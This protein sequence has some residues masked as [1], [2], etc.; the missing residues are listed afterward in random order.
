MAARMMKNRWLL[1][2]VTVLVVAWWGSCPG[3]GTAQTLDTARAALTEGRYQAAVSQLEELVQKEPTNLGTQYWLGRARLA[4]GDAAG[5]AEVFEKILEVKADSLESRLWLGR[6]LLAADKKTEARAAFEE[7]LARQADQREAKQALLEMERPLAAEAPADLL[8]A[9]ARELERGRLIFAGAGLGIPVGQSDITSANVYDYTFSYAPTDWI[10]RSGEWNATSRWT[11]SPQWSWYGGYSPQGLAAFWNKRQFMGDITVELHLAF[12]MRMGR[13]PVYMHPNDINITICG[14]GANLDSGYAFI[15]G[16]DDN[17]VTR[18]M[19]G[20]RVIAESRDPAALFP[21]YEN[22]QPATYEWHRKWWSLRARKSGTRLQL[23]LDEK[24]ILEGDDPH[25]LPGGRVALWVYKNDMITPRVKIYYEREKLP[26]DPMPDEQT[27]FLPVTSVTSPAVTVSSPSHPSFQADFETDLGSWT[28]REPDQGATLTIVPGGPDGQGHCL[29]LVNM[30][31][32]GHFGANVIPGQFDLAQLPRLRFDY[33]LDPEARVNFYFTCGDQRYELGFSGL[34]QCAPGYEM[35]GR[36]PGVRADGQWHQADYDLL[37]ALQAH[38]GLTKGTQC[39]GLWAGNL[40]NSTYLQA[41][42][43]GNR[44]GTQWEI[45]NFY[46]GHPRTGDV[47]VTVTPRPGVEI[48][49]LAVNLVPGTEGPLPEQAEIKDGKFAVRATGEGRHTVQ[50]RPLLK[51][52]QWGPV[53]RYALWVD[54]EAPQVVGSEPAAGGTL[55][56]GKIELQLADPGGSGV[57]L[58]ALKLNLAG[59]SLG[60]DSPAVAYDPGS[61]KVTLDLQQTDLVLPNNQQAVLEVAGLVDRAG[62]AVAESQPIGFVVDY[63]HDRTPPTVPQIHLGESY[64]LDNDFEHD[65]GEWTPYGGVS[66]AEL[67][68]DSTTASSGTYSLRLHNGATGRRFGAYITQRPFDAGKYRMVSF[69]YKCDDRLRADLAVY[70]NGAW[71]SIRFTD[72]DNHTNVIGQV[73]NVITDN[74][75]HTTSFNLYDMLRKADGAANFIVRQ[76]IISDWNWAGNRAGATYHIDDFQLIPVISGAAPVKA[77]WKSRDWSGIGGA[78]WVW[79]N[80]MGT[81]PAKKIMGEASETQLDLSE[82]QD[83][84]LHVRTQDRA[85]NWS[86]AGHRR[87]LVD[88]EAPAAQIYSPYPDARHAVS[89]VVVALSDKGISGVDPSTLKLKVGDSEYQVDGQGL[90]FEYSQGKLIWNCER[91]QPNPVVF[92]D[93]TEVDVA[94]LAGADYAGNKLPELPRWK[95]VMDYSLDQTPPQV[96]EIY[97]TTHPTLVTNTFEYGLGYWQNRGGD[98]GAKVELVTD[99]AADGKGCVQLTNQRKGGHM[100]AFVYREPYVVEKYPI[101]AFDYR[102]PAG[103]RLALQF[104]MDGRW[105]AVNLTDEAKDIIGQVPDII[106]DGKWRH[107]QFD[108]MPLLRRHKPQ[109]TLVVNQIFIGDRGTMNNEA[110][111]KAWFDNF[112]IG[113]VG[114]YAPVLRWRATDTTGISGYSQTLSRDSGAVPAAESEGTEVAKTF[115]NLEAGIWY[116][117]VRARDGAGNW[118]PPRTYAILHQNAD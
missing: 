97:S 29:R 66:G 23:Y 85:G 19:R 96:A 93:G 86:P 27:A 91:V 42:F 48:E 107:A 115:G 92:G 116:F 28:Q 3:V 35:I 1:L 53:Q 15:V 22:G 16:G 33:R 71:K 38:Q 54:R 105:F 8:E 79:D 7:V 24:L 83:G 77:S 73:P 34:E 112:I 110:G 87:V 17:R 70:V 109:G 52:G 44:Q 55:V 13:D 36:I 114:R 104:A 2:G 76:F 95:W 14:D 72:N 101:V 21:I 56:S 47:T 108:L 82:L 69:A 50:V 81:E 45:D 40:N 10:A 12:K 57:D 117:H 5:A 113:Q 62:N 9:T 11:C 4:Q 18:I 20:N 58:A 89:E 59:Q 6:A 88:A 65:M 46:L 84:W 32:G 100:E 99:Q 90:R 26:R 37:G 51:D 111:A 118:G 67:T 60:L 31:A 103:T 78:S 49:A 63:Q 25:P 106:A 39:G 94:L 64:F 80:L 102:I 75:W 98:N 61:G 43:G 68:R 41:G 74:Q 30:A